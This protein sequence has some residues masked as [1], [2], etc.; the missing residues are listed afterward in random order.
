MSP[1][2]LT[3]T[4]RLIV[5]YLALAP[6]AFAFPRRVDAWLSLACAHA[7][8]ILLILRPAPGDRMLRPVVHAAP[9]AAGAL[10][11]WYPLLLVPL[12]YAELPLLNQSIHGS[13]YFDPLILSWERTLFAGQPSRELAG[14]AP[15][16]W[17][18]ESLHAAYLSYYPIIYLPP[19]WIALRRGAAARDSTI[20]AVMLTFF[21]HYL[22][23]IAFPV[24][25]PRYRFPQPDG[26]TGRGPLQALTHAILEAGSSRGAAFP[27]A[28]VGIAA[29]QCVNAY[30]HHARLL[31]PLVPIT[32]GLSIGAVYGGFHYA[33][34]VIAGA[35]LG[36]IT[37]LAAPTLH[38][39]L[40]RPA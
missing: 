18:S 27:S 14:A 7:L 11:A 1:H 5:V 37:A 25:G 2:R 36:L 23:F 3:P 33:V 38:R 4:D 29:A 31:V 39:V 6:V 16:R 26:T 8:L 32:I 34:D 22:L 13:R 12:F 9:R 35:G 15:W 10:H 20:F 17:L 40:E 24:E 21:V 30:R 28:H 19:I